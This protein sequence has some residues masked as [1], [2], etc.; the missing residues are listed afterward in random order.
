MAGHKDKTAVIAGA[1]KASAG[2][3]K[4][5]AEDGGRR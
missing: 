1:A 2:F 4:R 3:A 5:L